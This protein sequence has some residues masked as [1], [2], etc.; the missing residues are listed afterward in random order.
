MTKR[1][2]MDE[3]RNFIE[4]YTSN[5]SERIMMDDTLIDYMLEVY[6][7]PVKQV[8][9]RYDREFD[10]YV[11][12]RSDGYPDFKIHS[13]ER[14]SYTKSFVELGYEVHVG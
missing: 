14:E 1:Q 2:L 8:S 5:E 11:V 6:Q 4:Y 10:G 3:I 13:S 12:R 9:F 7:P